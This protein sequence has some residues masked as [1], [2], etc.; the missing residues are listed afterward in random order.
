MNHKSL[1]C[2]RKEPVSEEKIVLLCARVRMSDSQRVRLRE[3]SLAGADWSRVVALARMHGLSPLVFRH[4]CETLGEDLPKEVYAEL[5]NGQ[6]RLERHNSQM[7][8][9]LQRILETFGEHGIPAIPYKGPT[10][11]MAAYGDLALREY[12]DLDLLL[13]RSDILRAKDLLARMDFM[14]EYDLSPEAER[15]LLRSRSR[16]HM[17]LLREQPRLLVELHWKT[18]PEFP[19]EPV[20]DESWW[21][22]LASFRLGERDLPSFSPSELMLVLCLHGTKHFWASLGWLVDI[23]ELIRQQAGLDWPWIIKRA[24]ALH[25]DRRLALGLI[26][27]RDV[28]EVELPEAVQ[29]WLHRQVEATRVAGLVC[30]EL[31][32]PDA[33][34]RSAFARLQL[35]FRLYQ[36]WGQRLRH[37]IDVV[38]NPGLV[39]WSGTNLP[40]PLFFLYQPIRWFRLLRKYAT[41]GAAR[42]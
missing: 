11:A 22:N 8:A 19:V 38:F 25:A 16:Y 30:S 35:N 13:R 29:A 23:A 42:R 2:V 4:L 15:R 17:A 32:D 20:G 7:T 3:F 28:L 39:E 9:D 21:A 5:W 26:L 34:E 18:D 41:G 31:F 1:H 24:E 27:V 10:L 14:P 33:S 40:R 36:S 6:R 37:V 12:G